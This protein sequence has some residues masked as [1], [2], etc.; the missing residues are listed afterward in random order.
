[1]AITFTKAIPTDKWIFSEN[2]RIVEFSSDYAGTPLYCDITI[3][4]TSYR[5][6][7]LPDGTFWINLGEPISKEL[8]NYDDDLNLNTIDPLAISTFIFDWSKVYFNGLIVIQITHS[9]LF[10]DTATARPHV[11]L[12]AEQLVNF[13]KGMTVTNEPKFILSPLKK[14]TT[15]TYYLNYWDG[16]PFDF[17]LTKTIPTA[18]TSQTITNHTNGI[19][20]T[21]IPVPYDVNRI[22]IS[23][24]DTTQTLED[25]LPLTEGL[26]KLELTG[27]VFIEL[28]KFNPKCGVYV[29]WLNESGGYTYWLFNEFFEID[30]N[31]KSKGEINK[32]FNNLE[33]T[34][35]TFNN[36]GKESFD[37]YSLY[38]DA[39]NVHEINIIKQILTSNKVYL[40]TGVRYSVNTFNDWLEVNVKT[41]GANLKQSREVLNDFKVEIEIPN[42]YHISL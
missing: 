25:Y 35:S 5:F 22:V 7:P 21:A 24:G 11:I 14:G 23:N 39:L 27:S 26:N 20:S 28:Y 2:N 8:S 17:G 15:N 30:K 6:Y 16:Y 9:D 40:F 1:M 37:T 41:S 38:A 18:Q 13:K 4:G 10:V 36:L 42:E 12:G 33:D 32:D 19:V 29:K 31:V 34:V 3:G